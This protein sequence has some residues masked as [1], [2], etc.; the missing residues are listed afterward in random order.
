[1]PGQPRQGRDD[2]LVAALRQQVGGV[3][4]SGDQG[5]RRSV[6]DRGGG[7]VVSVHA[8]AAQG[9]EERAGRCLPRIDDDGAVDDG[10]GAR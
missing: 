9:D 6:R 1:M 2:S 3:D 5:R 10:F 8:I 7:E 4:G